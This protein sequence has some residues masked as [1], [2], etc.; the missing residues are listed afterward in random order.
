MTYDLLQYVL[1]R[2][3]GVILVLFQGEEPAQSL[4]LTSWSP[5][6]SSKPVTHVRYADTNREKIHS[7]AAKTRQHVLHVFQFSCM[8]ELYSVQVHVNVG[9][10]YTSD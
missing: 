3:P 6:A 10:P 4:S 9:C 7:D 5:K 1:G 2:G 8:I